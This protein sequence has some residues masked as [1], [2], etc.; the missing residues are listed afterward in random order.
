MMKNIPQKIYLQIGEDAEDVESFDDLSDV[1]W[2]ADNINQND[3]EYVVAGYAAALP[4]DKPE[5]KEGDVNEII[6]KFTKF[7]DDRWIEKTFNNFLIFI[8]A[9]Y[10]AQPLPID[11]AQP[12]GAYKEGEL[13]DMIGKA[14]DKAN[15]E[16]P[17]LDHYSY[18]IG[19]KD[20]YAATPAYKGDEPMKIVFTDLKSLDDNIPEDKR[21]MA[22]IKGVAIVTADSK[23][24]AFDEILKSLKVLLAYNSNHQLPTP[25]QP[26]SVQEGEKEAVEGWIRV[27]DR[28]PD[29]NTP[30][31][32]NCK[33]Y[34][35]YIA[36]YNFIGE[37]NGEKYGNWHDG[38]N[39]GAL[40]PSHWMPLPAPPQQ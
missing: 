38:K 8:K 18:K 15:K 39:L 30:V 23:E 24:K 1:T 13:D 29:F 5:Y 9:T 33:I 26:N 11:K 22:D 12:E 32:V 4:I 37:F 20:S 16:Y 2:C 28:L 31:F 3:I 21:W 6:A 40:P 34:G 27:E 14:W 36:S 7:A 17:E 10:P 25:T 19:F 35:R